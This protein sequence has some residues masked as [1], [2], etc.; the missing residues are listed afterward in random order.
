MKVPRNCK[1][2]G[3]EFTAVRDWHQYCSGRCN[4]NAYAR[5]RFFGLDVAEY[6]RLLAEQK[7]VCRICQEQPTT[8]AVDHDHKSGKVRGLLCK[9]C[10]LG[11]GHFRE[12]VESLKAAITYLG[13]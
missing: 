2:C 1:G 12:D 13:G 9:W 5:R 3:V 6:Q 8:L 10:N 4:H 7:G 11:L